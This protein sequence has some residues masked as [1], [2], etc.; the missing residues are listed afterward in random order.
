MK[1]LS[2]ST[3]LVFLFLLLIGT[4][5]CAGETAD[6]SEERATGG[7]G[8]SPAAEH[9]RFTISGPELARTTFVF[10]P[11]DFTVTNT[12]DM[13]LI[14]AMNTQA[15][16]GT[17][18]M[19][20]QLGVFQVPGP[21]VYNSRDDEVVGSWSQSTEGLAM[22]ITEEADMEMHLT[23]VD[24]YVGATFHGTIEHTNSADES[25]PLYTIEDGSFLVRNAR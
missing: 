20:L 9:V 11:A 19:A 13:Y 12:A 3:R 10:D 24:G 25:S 4:V 1:L 7:R 21:G 14:R 5:A 15:K 2:R 16:D 22:Q 6:P 8:G 18:F 23:H 17:P